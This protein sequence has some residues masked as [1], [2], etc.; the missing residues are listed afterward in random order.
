MTDKPSS[1]AVLTLNVWN[2]EGPWPDRLPLI[3]SWIDRLQ[4]DL[5][6]LQEVVN[7]RNSGYQAK[8]SQ[9]VARHC[10]AWSIP[11]TGPSHLP[12]RLLHFT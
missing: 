1:L 3:K 8:T 2:R 12:V 5:I 7:G 9:P 10:A 4:P 6:G 11:P